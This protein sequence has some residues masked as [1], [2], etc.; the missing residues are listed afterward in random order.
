MVVLVDV[1]GCPD[2]T[3]FEEAAGEGGS[4]G[5]VD[6]CGGERL[7]TLG[8]TPFDLEG[9]VEGGGACRYPTKGKR[10]GLCSEAVGGNG[11]SAGSL[12]SLL[13]EVEGTL[14]FGPGLSSPA[15]PDAPPIELDAPPPVQLEAPLPL[16]PA[17]A[18]PSWETDPEPKFKVEDDEGAGGAS[19]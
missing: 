1:D 19:Q 9:Y 10:T 12:V 7:K 15:E 5:A 6:S 14:M 13:L 3:E 11:P 2:G 16:P 18:P 8:G 4:G 17:Q